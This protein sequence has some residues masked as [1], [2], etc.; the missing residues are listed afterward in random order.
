MLVAMRRG[1]SG[2]VG[3]GHAL[4][5]VVLVAHLRAEAR[6]TAAAHEAVSSK[7][8]DLERRQLARNLPVL[9]G[10]QDNRP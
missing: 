1:C 9:A 4:G 5:V 8:G 2:T 6:A 10:K 3:V 7:V